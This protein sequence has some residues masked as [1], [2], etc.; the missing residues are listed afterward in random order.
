MKI[1]TEFYPKARLNCKYAKPYS[2]LSTAFGVKHVKSPTDNS[3]PDNSPTPDNSSQDKSTPMY[4][5][6]QL[7]PYVYTQTKRPLGHK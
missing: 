4:L 5:L 2:H 1:Y 3:S 7:V 6:R